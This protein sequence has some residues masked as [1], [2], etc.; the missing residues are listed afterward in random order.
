LKRAA[1]WASSALGER[2]TIVAAHDAMAQP[3]RTLRAE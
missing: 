3:G 1:V 2:E